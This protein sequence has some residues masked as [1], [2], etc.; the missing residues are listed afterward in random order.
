MV[1]LRNFLPPTEGLHH[2]QPNTRA[3]FE[4]ECLGKGT[5][6]V[7][8]STLCWLS[9]SGQGFSLLYPSIAIH[10]ISRDVNN[11][12]E[13]CI[14]MMV[15]DKIV[16]DE[17][18]NE[19]SSAMNSMNVSS[20]DDDDEE[21]ETHELLFVPDD[22][23]MLQAVFTAITECSALNPGPKDEYMDDGDG[24][25]IFPPID[26]QYGNPDLDSDEEEEILD[27]DKNDEQ[28]EDAES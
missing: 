9:T 2:V 16:L 15:N 19:L 21:E 13:P 11:F 4:S 14:F 18:P 1:V 26:I 25:A 10:A 20:S 12:P 22:L 27:E 17:D 6:Y 28:F 5:L 24:E 7:S 3:F 8:K 23:N